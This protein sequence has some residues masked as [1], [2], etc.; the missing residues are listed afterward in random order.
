MSL[1]LALPRDLSV[2][3]T[4]DPPA[5]LSL[6]VLSDGRAGNDHQSLGVAA[7]LGVAAPVI[8]PLGTFRHGLTQWLPVPWVYGRQTLAAIPA[9]DLVVAT[10]WQMGRVS[11]WLKRQRARSTRPLFTVQLLR[12]SGRPDDYDVLALPWHDARKPLVQRWTGAA[13]NVVVTAGAANIV[14]PELL[15]G[16]AARWE[17]A[18]RRLP[19]PR[20]AVLI[21]GDSRHGP[22]RPELARQLIDSLLVWGRRSRGSLLVTTSRRSGAQIG[23]LVAARLKGQYLVDYRFWRPDDPAAGDNP[24]L[25]YLAAADAV[26]A[27]DDSISMISEGLTAGKPVYLFGDAARVPAKFRAFFDRM[28]R[29]GRLTQW[30]G[31]L[32]L[33][34]PADRLNDAALVADFVRARYRAADTLAARQPIPQRRVSP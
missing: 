20:L 34:P 30:N 32:D 18:L 31:A 3:V 2:A 7:A 14:T 19:G 25:G 13:E 9:A 11:R 28:A 12:S 8:V 5:A 26:V 1:D 6:I 24:Y 27:T 17:P 22:L 33:I 15:A 29:Q 10:G 16:A 4:A 21:G 23:D